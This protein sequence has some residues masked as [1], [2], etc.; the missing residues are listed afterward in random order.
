M[1]I[2]V[3]PECFTMFTF[4]GTWMPTKWSPNSLK[5]I[6]YQFYS[7]I[8]VSLIYTLTVS[9]FFG[10]IFLTENLADFT[11]I[12]FLL[13]STI[14]VCGKVASIMLNRSKVIGLR[15]ML[16]E[17]QCVPRNEEEVKILRMFDK[18]A[19]LVV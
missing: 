10:A 19:R 4:G 18:I 1:E 9:E 15:N 6:I 8:C 5:A 3:L 13:V 14:S 12:S 17:N 2:S 7:L 16:M 11:D